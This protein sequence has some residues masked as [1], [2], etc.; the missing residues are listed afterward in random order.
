M[1]VVYEAEEER[2]SRRVALKVLPTSLLTQSKQIQ[3]FEREARAAARLHH[4][5]IVPVFG[6]GE[7]RGYYYY[8]MQFIEGKSLATILREQ[9]QASEN[10]SALSRRHRPS[11]AADTKIDGYRRVAQIGL[12]VAE[13]LD[14]AHRQGILHRDIKPSNLIQDEKGVVWVADFGLAKTP[15]ADELTSAGELLG[16]I[17]YMAPE[18]FR[19]HC[20]ERSDVYGLGMTLYELA[21]RRP[22]YDAV[23]RYELMSEIR[24]RDPVP[25]R[26]C[27]RGIP[28]DLETI[29]HKAIDRDPARRY[30]TALALADD[31]RR[32][33]T[34]GRSCAPAVARRASRT[35][36]QAK[37][38]G[39][40][41]FAGTGARRDRQ[42]LAGH[43]RDLRR[44]RGET[45]RGDHPERA[46][47][48]RTSERS[49]TGGGE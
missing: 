36:V 19:G 4:T 16:T 39:L 38:V 26:K 5:N 43:P 40:G 27:A 44:A 7:E 28:R 14:H 47:P 42:R 25:L 10:R 2:L 45:G 33:S 29:I 37:S 30:S 20:D 15:D 41:L 13:A 46:R 48:R 34:A 35:L 49:R 8:F 31:L 32:S 11:R 12:Q 18:R 6:V 24:Q 1:G 3:R 9:S 22:A 17:R 21:A 23:D